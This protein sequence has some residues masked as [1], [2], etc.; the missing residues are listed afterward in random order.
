M[1]SERKKKQPKNK[2]LDAKNAKMAERVNVTM[3]YFKILGIWIKIIIKKELTWLAK[4]EGS[5]VYRER[6]RGPNTLG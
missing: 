2:L 3:S 4:Y 5:S 1:F 6:P